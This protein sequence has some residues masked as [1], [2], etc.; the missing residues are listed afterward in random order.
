MEPS[1][2][3]NVRGRRAESY[4][5][6]SVINALQRM[7]SGNGLSAKDQELKRR[8]GS[9]L[10]VEDGHEHGEGEVYQH[11][12]QDEH[13]ATPDD[14]EEF[15]DITAWHQDAFTQFMEE[16]N[17]PEILAKFK[18]AR[19][20]LDQA[21]V[22]RGFYPVRNPNYRGKGKGR[23]KG[24]YNQEN[25][26][27]DKICMRCGK[28]EHIARS[29]PQRTGNTGG[30]NPSTSHGQ[31]GFVGAAFKTEEAQVHELDTAGQTWTTQEGE[32]VLRGKLSLT[33]AHRTMWL[34]SI[35]SR[36]WQKSLGIWASTWKRNLKLTET[37]TRTSSMVVITA[38]RP[39][40]LRI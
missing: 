12:V 33:V 36:S 4:K 8:K 28:R 38:A 27:A 11:E 14:D 9:A 24:N 5:L 34:V 6:D 39:W 16:P 18:D 19:K 17:E 15:D 40:G 22:A 2:V 26:H 20:A 29:C 13:A 30:S 3:A 21:K 35:L 37:F 10:V 7:W 23:G 1:D 25:P 32:N 31:V